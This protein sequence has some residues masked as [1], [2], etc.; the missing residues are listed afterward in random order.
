MYYD[1]WAT[2]KYFL[3]FFYLSLFYFILIPT[4]SWE[5]LT[6][7]ITTHTQFVALFYTYI[8]LNVHGPV[9]LS[10]APCITQ[11]FF[12]DQIVLLRFEVGF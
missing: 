4:L 12:F 3:A 7:P 8:L 5:G 1:L 2:I 10:T 11:I 6:Y 9:K